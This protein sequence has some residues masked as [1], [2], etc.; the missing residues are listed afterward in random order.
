[1][2]V[3]VADPA[4]WSTPLKITIMVSITPYTLAL[5]LSA[6]IALNAWLLCRRPTTRRALSGSKA[7]HHQGVQQQQRFS[8][9]TSAPPQII[10]S[11]MAAVERLCEL[12]DSRRFLEAGTLLDCA[13]PARRMGDS[14]LGEWHG[15]L[16]PP[17][18]R[19]LEERLIPACLS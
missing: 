1:M 19:R 14:L 8:T 6:S 12:K 13:L 2:S 5:L 18:S 7:R 11:L 9:T 17:R 10:S 3:V 4:D 15:I 16:H